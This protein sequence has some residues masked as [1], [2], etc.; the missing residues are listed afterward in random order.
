MKRPLSTFVL[1]CLL[2]AAAHAYQLRVGETTNA[3]VLPAG[4][5]IAEE[6]LWAANSVDIQG[7]TLRDLWLLATAAIRFDGESGG[8]LRAFSASAT[9]DGTVQG[10]LF[11]YANGLQLTTNSAVRGEVALF[12]ADLIC[13]G[14]V[15]GDARLFA[16]SATLG[17]RWGGD[18]RI[19]ADEIRIAPDTRIAGDLVYTSSKPLVY[20]A[21]VTVGGTV[22][23]RNVLPPEAPLRSRLA[24]HGYLF[25]AALLVGMPFVGFFPMVAGGA[26][27]KLRASPWRALLAGLAALLFGPV[28]IAFAFVTIVGIPLALMLAS[29]YGALLY[30]AHVVIALWLGH[31]LVRASGPQ[32]F[33]RVLSA[34]AVGLFILYFAAA[35]PGVASFLAFPVVV[36]GS[37]S[38]VLAFLQRSFIPI[39]MPPPVPPPLPK[40]PEPTD[41]PE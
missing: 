41:N 22:E 26:V 34:L 20:D 21:S 11:A 7:T 3:L 36:L 1:L 23:Q 28:L 15:E 9:I 33:A 8:D 4:A 32:T 10:N 6:A 17:G 12:G 19:V 14:A 25:L 39:A 5:Q 24:R 2:P 37:G 16:K 35:I 18:V 40:R 31:A 38:L 27:R 13:E 30:L 29:L